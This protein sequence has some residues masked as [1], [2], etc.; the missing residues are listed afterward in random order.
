MLAAIHQP[1]FL[2]RLK[3]LQKIASADIWVVLDD[4]QYV[5]RE[6]QNRARLRHFRKLDEEYWLTVPVHRPRGRRSVISEIAMCDPENTKSKISR[7]L[8]VSY[9][10]SPHWARVA[11]ILDH[12]TNFPGPSLSD[13]NTLTAE[14][15]V[16][17]LGLQC[18]PMVR[19]S[20]FR[21]ADQG[22][23]RLAE[24]CSRVN[25]TSYLSGS[26][27]R[28]YLDLLPFREKGIEVKWQLWPDPHPSNNKIRSRNLSA[29]DSLARGGYVSPVDPGSGSGLS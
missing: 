16:S 25:A 21:I 4:V 24:I 7:A 28:N 3:V 12:L 15:L 20:T 23:Q 11:G 22:S 10:R 19:S 27:G 13:F 1:N 18:P 8:N 17:A 5:Q 29:I 26:G 2:P 6:W 14:L 9:G